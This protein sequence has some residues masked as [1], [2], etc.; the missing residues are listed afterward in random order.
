MGRGDFVIIV[1]LPCRRGAKE[2]DTGNLLK[3]NFFQKYVFSS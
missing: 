2:G 3:K 1:S